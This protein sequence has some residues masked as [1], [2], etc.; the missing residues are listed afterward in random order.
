M[1]RVLLYFFAGLLVCFAGV[2]V[3]GHFVTG[4]LFKDRIQAAQTRSQNVTDYEHW[5]EDHVTARIL[6]IAVAVGLLLGSL[7]GM[8]A[9]TQR[10]DRPARKP[11]PVRPRAKGEDLPLTSPEFDRVAQCCLFVGIAEREP[12]FVQGVIVGRLVDSEPELAHKVG[13]FSPEH[14]AALWKDLAH[15]SGLRFKN[16]RAGV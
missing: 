2:Y 9:A 3:A 13:G 14:M 1:P 5:Y 7:G 8:R 15:L 6:P 16:G 10:K 12:S 4:L 11:R